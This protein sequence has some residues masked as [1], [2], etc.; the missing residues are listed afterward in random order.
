MSTASISIPAGMVMTPSMHLQ[1]GHA[2]DFL[3]VQVA[4]IEVALSDRLDGRPSIELADDGNRARIFLA[5]PTVVR[6]G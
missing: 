5:R 2:I 3:G 1:L 6:R 4:D